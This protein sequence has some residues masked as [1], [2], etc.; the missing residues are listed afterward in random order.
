MIAPINNDNNGIP[1]IRLINKIGRQY[2][3]VGDS[4]STLISCN[5]SAAKRKSILKSIRTS[6]KHKA[7]KVRG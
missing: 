6:I 1:E 7:T 3:K 2:S 4:G 5:F